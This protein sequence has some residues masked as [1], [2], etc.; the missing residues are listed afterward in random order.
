MQLS[1]AVIRRLR[2]STNA[3]SKHRCVSRRKAFALY[4]EPENAPLLAVGMNQSLS[5]WVSK[6][7]QHPFGQ[8]WGE[9]PTCEDEACGTSLAAAE[10]T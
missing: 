3:L 1:P 4:E 10:F 9:C 6:G 7:A 2:Q 5:N 8:G